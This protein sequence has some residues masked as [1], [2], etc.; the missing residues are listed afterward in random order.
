MKTKRI[1]ILTAEEIKALYSQPILSKARRADVFSFD[2]QILEQV[3]DKALDF[4]S[5]L[6]LMLLV[7]YYRTKWV[8]PDVTLRQAKEDVQYLCS[9]Y[10]P[11]RKPVYTRIPSSTCARL[12]NKAMAIINVQ[13][14]ES[15]HQK[16]LVNKLKDV[17]TISADPR[18]LFDESLAFL[19]QVR[20]VLPGYTQLQDSIS[21][22]L[23]SEQERLTCTLASHMKPATVKALTELLDEDGALNQLAEHKGAKD[24]GQTQIERELKIHSTIQPLYNDLKALMK[25]LNV[26]MGNMEYY[27]S[28]VRHQSLYFLR[29]YNKWQGFL[30]LSS[31]LYFRYRQSNDRLTDALI[32]WVRKLNQ[33]ALDHAKQKVADDL[34]TVRGKLNQAGVV[35]GLFADGTIDHS[36]TFGE[37]RKK[38]YKILSKREIALVSQH[39][40]NHDFDKNDYKW[41]FIES[42]HYKVS[43]LLRKIYCAIDFNTHESCEMISKILHI[44]RQNLKDNIMPQLDR[45][46]LSSSV[47]TYLIDENDQQISKR[48]E[49]YLYYRLMKLMESDSI[50][51]EESEKN[52]CLES[53]LIS[54]IKWKKEENSIR[55]STG[56]ESMTKPV[57]EILDNRI[58]YLDQIR[59]SLTV[60]INQNNNVFI[61]R[62]PGKNQLDWSRPHPKSRIDQDNPIYSQ[63]HQKSIV[64][65]LRF[66]NDRVGFLKKFKILA[67]RKKGLQADDNDLLAGILAN[68]GGYGISRMA[69]SSDRT[70]AAL[71]TVNDLY[72]TSDNISQA[73]DLIASAMAKLPIFEDYTINAESPFASIDGQK[74]SCRLNTFK[75][76]YSSKYF[77][78]GQ[79]VSVISVVFN[80]MPITTEVTS[81]NEHESWFLFD[82]FYNNSSEITPRS[83]T[84]DQHGTNG[85]NFAILDLFGQNF[86]PRYAKFKN[87]FLDSFDVGYTDQSI[88]ITLKKPINTDLIRSEWTEIQRIICSL[89]R[90]TTKQS[91]IIKKLNRNKNSYKTLAALHEYNRLIKS[92]YLLEYA[93]DEKLRGFIQAALCRGEQ[94]HQ[95]RRAISNIS[96]NQFKG[97]NDFELAQW[98][99]CGRLI[100]SSIIYYNSVILSELKN[101][102]ERKQDKKTTKL[103]S[104][105]SPIAWSHVSLMGFYSFEGLEVQAIDVDQL[106]EEI[107]AESIDNEME[108]VAASNNGLAEYRA[109]RI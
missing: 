84:S 82:L 106:L 63:L 55:S 47:R 6:Y 3:T 9:R 43:Q 35:L 88:M 27:A 102:F 18:F 50:F 11:H 39:L 5:Q 67:S 7:G 80:N 42:K 48:T 14:F 92:I 105:L 103:I 75:A 36:I 86:A 58:A 97:G 57:N 33:S 30:Y 37:A 45:R 104:Q 40:S 13:R 91:T 21:S 32:F 61:Q 94:Y 70:L 49:F 87:I 20:V 29:R 34:E 66:V 101:T 56:L 100:A 23:A 95:L 98:N 96:G 71:N 51:I 8:V 79:G 59:S 60:Q 73:H 10:F 64:E 44:T 107:S 46:F 81:A 12:H 53:D 41:E 17:V 68:G 74:H 89:S 72:L 26:S 1:T 22:V 83:L 90:K 109:T 76:R 16:R 54:K 25:R 85:V 15:K 31:Y 62:P 28:M 65:V 38:A 77:R 19:T 108:A 93:H 78:Q 24:F 52:R 69:S 4:R 99:E 2:A